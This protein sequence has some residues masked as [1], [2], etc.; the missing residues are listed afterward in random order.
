MGE[1]IKIGDFGRFVFQFCR[2]MVVKV[3]GKE[4]KLKFNDPRDMEGMEV[5]EVDKKTILLKDMSGTV[6]MLVDRK[7]IKSFEPDI[8]PTK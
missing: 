1:R 4:R 2:E 7:Y 3:N 5:V 8:K 6:K